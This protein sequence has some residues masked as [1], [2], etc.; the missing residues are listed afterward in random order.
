MLNA[1]LVI[2]ALGVRP[3]TSWQ[4]WPD[5]PSANAAASS[6]IRRCGPPILISGPSGDVVEVPD[7]L[8]GQITVP[9]LAGPPTAKVE[10]RQESI[11]GRETRFRGIQATAVVGVLLGMTVASAGASRRA[12]DAP[13][14]PTSKVYHIL[15][16]TRVT[17]RRARFTSSCSFSVP[18]G[19]ILGARPSAWKASRSAST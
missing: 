17:P 15:A 14:S 10:L 8:L 18:D 16:I 19:R 13:V 3:E 9:P 2:L 11:A 7:V 1:D 6:S 4:E 5:S 12:F